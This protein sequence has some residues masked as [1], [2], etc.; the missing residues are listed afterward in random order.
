[1]IASS[2]SGTR[3]GEGAQD[4]GED[5]VNAFY[6]AGDDGNDDVVSRRLG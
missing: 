6:L 3:A 2:T 4:V 1:M 5:D